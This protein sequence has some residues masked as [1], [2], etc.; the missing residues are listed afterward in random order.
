MEL[1]MHFHHPVKLFA[2]LGALFLFVGLTATIIM[3]LVNEGKSGKST[4]FDWLFLLVLYAVCIS[5]IL[6]EVLRLMNN[7]QAAYTMYFIHLVT[8]FFLIAYFPYSKFAHVVFRT[9]AI[10]YSN[11]IG[12]HTATGTN[13]KETAAAECTECQEPEPEK[14]HATDNN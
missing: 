3:R 2:N 11:M 14:E 5:G 7:G 10:A 6:T 4:Y 12:R 8:I 13:G 9:V 1:P